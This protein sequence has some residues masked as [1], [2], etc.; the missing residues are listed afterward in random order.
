MSA[1]YMIQ[2]GISIAI[3]LLFLVLRKIF[4]KYV[5]QLII[6]VS[7]RTPTDFFTHI[8]LSIE[9]PLRW[10]FVL[11]GLY[12]AINY[13]PFF[14]QEMQLV[15]QFYR[16]SIVILLAW[17]LYNLTGVSSMFFD[18]INRRF[19]LDM[20]D[21]LAP[22][23]SKVLRFLIFALTFSIVAQE[24]HYDVNG[25]VAGLGLGGLAFALAAKDTIGNFFGGIILITEKPFTIGDWINTPNAEGVVEEI[26]FRSTKIRTFPQA[27]VTVPN[28]TIANEPI[29]NWTKMGKRQ[30][31]FTLSVTFKTTEEQL[32]TGV[33]RLEKMLREHNGIH[34]DVVSVAFE[35]FAAHGLDVHINCFTKTTDFSAHLKIKQDIN[36]KIMKIF[37]EEGIS[38]AYPTQTVILEKA[39]ETVLDPLNKRE[40]E[41]V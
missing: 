27:L 29:T 24:F 8:L 22:F 20:D 39:E 13:S 19:E 2:A 35:K 28:S 5:F 21:I 34:D 15:N 36:F 16:S 10:F 41:H 38:F 11:I 33:K 26:S 40:H 30:I 6:K 18:K 1:A 31:T 9:K 23:L 25:F 12:T 32:H 4:T 7:H 14:D 37:E 17:G 3:L